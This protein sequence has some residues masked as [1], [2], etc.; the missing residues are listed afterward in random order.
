M[1]LDLTL[2]LEGFDDFIDNLK[3]PYLPLLKN[4][5]KKLGNLFLCNYC[6][7]YHHNN[8]IMSVHLRK[9]HHGSVIEPE[10]HCIISGKNMCVICNTKI[11]RFE[12]HY[13][14]CHKD[15][16]CTI[17]GK[18]SKNMRCFRDH[19]KR[20][21]KDKYKC[22][23]CNYRNSQ[24]SNMKRHLFIEHFSFLNDP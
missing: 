13:V 23:Y 9:C 15:L 10:D 12:G 22:K 6:Q 3:P 17:C 8:N 7:F 4:G 1:A 24:T 21:K 14:N 11:T 19:L 18:K 5:F 16:Q 2:D 20:H